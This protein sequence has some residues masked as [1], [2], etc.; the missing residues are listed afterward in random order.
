MAL[1]KWGHRTWRSMRRMA[2]SAHTVL[3]EPVG[4]A[5][6]T[7]SAV[8]YS[9]L[10]TCQGNT[11]KT[12]VAPLLASSHQL[13]AAARHVKAAQGMGRNM[14]GLQ[15]DMRHVPNQTPTLPSRVS[16][17]VSCMPLS[18]RRL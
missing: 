18:D 11:K 1:L 4:A 8:L 7:F 17:T 6:S 16:K 10:N 13:P 12:G 5:T 3:P 9:V 14:L 2:N 15:P